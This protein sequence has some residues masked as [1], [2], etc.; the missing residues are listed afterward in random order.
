M[1]LGMRHVLMV[2]LQFFILP[3]RKRYVK[4]RES[5]V[6]FRSLIHMYVNRKQYIKV[7]G[8]CFQMT[9]YLISYLGDTTF[10]KSL[11]HILLKISP[12]F[13]LI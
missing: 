13:D 7:H 12:T 10:H 11:R 1:T 5:L 4:M 8:V 2:V 3:Y 9:I 6:R